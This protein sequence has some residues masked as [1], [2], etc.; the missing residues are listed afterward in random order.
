LYAKQYE[1]FSLDWAYYTD[2]LNQNSSINVTWYLRYE[3]GGEYQESA[4]GTGV[5]AKGTISSPLRFIPEVWNNDP[6]G[7]EQNKGKAYLIAKEGNTELTSF[8]IIID[9]SSYNISETAGAVLKLSAYGKS[10]T[11]SDKDQW[12]DSIGGVTTTFNNIMYDDRSGWTDN[13][14]FV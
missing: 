6:S 3:D 2:H 13:A 5:G 12:I 4:I 7:N 9:K 14:L 11:A 10:N 8:E 1:P